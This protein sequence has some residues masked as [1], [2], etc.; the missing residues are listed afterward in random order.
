MLRHLYYV[1][2][3]TDTIIGASNR[4]S[5]Y[6]PLAAVRHCS[7]G[8]RHKLGNLATVVMITSMPLCHKGLS[9]LGA[10]TPK[11]IAIVKR[12]IQEKLHEFFILC[13]SSH[14]HINYEGIEVEEP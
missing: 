6:C 2:V 8:L 5:G 11:D 10:N 9:V 7:V 14:K 12:H 1:P 13:D 4:S 3:C